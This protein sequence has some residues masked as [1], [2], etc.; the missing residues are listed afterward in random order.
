MRH[1]LQAGY[2]AD[3]TSAYGQQAVVTIPAWLSILAAVSL[4]LAAVCALIVLG[5]I[6]AGHR[7]K[8]AVMN[9]VWPLTLLY[10]GLLGLWAYFAFGR[11]P[12]Q[13]E[14]EMARSSHGDQSDGADEMHSDDKSSKPPDWRAVFKGVTHCG[15]GCTLGDVLGDWIVFSLG[16]TAAGIAFWPKLIAEFVGAFLLGIVFQ[17][18]AIVPM[19]HLKPWEGIRA[20]L[21]AD[22]LSITAFEVGM[23]AW[24][25]FVRFGIFHR[26]LPPTEPVYWFLMQIAMLIGFAT[27]YPMNRWLIQKGWKEAM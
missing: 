15:A 27:S 10:M 19:R 3:F 18:F 26:D 21:K 8:M 2:P 14:Q 4:E 23:L 5:D 1:E 17:Y 25:A 6:L 24:M 12:E 9:W 11:A 20:A 7:Q 13:P 16:I 22:T